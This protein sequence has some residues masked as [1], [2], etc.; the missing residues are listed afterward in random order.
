MKAVEIIFGG[1]H[2]VL[3]TEGRQGEGAMRK[4]HSR[5]ALQENFLWQWKCS[6]ICTNTVATCG[7][8]A[9]EM[10]LGTEFQML[11][12]LIN[13]NL[14][15]N[16]HMR[17]TATVL[18]T[19]PIEILSQVPSSQVIFLFQ[20]VGMLSVEDYKAITKVSKLFSE[21]NEPVQLSVMTGRWLWSH[22]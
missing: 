14:K 20:H 5:A 17:L 16:S 18:D 15:I 7:Y 9:F 12:I 8:L 11:L 2:F 22:S 13:L 21:T 3:G 6:I 19:A 1:S 4:V 10:W